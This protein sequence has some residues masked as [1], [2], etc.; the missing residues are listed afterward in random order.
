[1]NRLL[2]I[3]LLFVMTQTIVYAQEKGDTKKAS[4]RRQNKILMKEQIK[5]LK[6][7]VLLVRLYTKENSIIA[8]KKIGRDEIANKT[9]K[10][11]INYNKS[12]I[13]AFRNNFTFCP[14]Y[15]FFSN[16]SDSIL[17]KQINGIIFLN[18][19]LQPDST[20]KI[21]GHNFLTAEF[22][23]I[24]QDTAKYFNGYYYYSSD[25]GLGK[26]SSYYGGPD[27]RFGVLKIMSDQLIQ[28]K[29]PFP[30]YVRTYDK[31]K[32]SKVVSNMNKNLRNYYEKY[33]GS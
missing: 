9:E 7:G 20:I 3:F 27:M 17:S 21:N 6:D 1:M 24:E 19:S 26:R 5:K 30:Y 16:F 29:K 32:L 14:T 18:D 31:R 4:Y 11:Q 15:F 10:K 12:I 28:L 13:S 33:N 25:S 23:I 8:L 22:G 2:S